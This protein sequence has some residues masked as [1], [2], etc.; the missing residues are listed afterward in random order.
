VEKKGVI[1]RIPSSLLGRVFPILS[2]G[3]KYGKQIEIL[4]FAFFL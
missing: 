2:R 4:V 1:K 3:S